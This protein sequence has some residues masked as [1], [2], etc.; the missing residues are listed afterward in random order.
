METDFQL[1][2]G[3]HLDFLAKL[4]QETI[5]ANCYHCFW[6]TSAQTFLQCRCYFWQN[7]VFVYKRDSSIWTHSFYLENDENSPSFG[8][9]WNFS[10]LEDEKLWLLNVMDFQLVI[11]WPFLTCLRWSFVQGGGSG[12]FVMPR[13]IFTKLRKIYFF[14]KNFY[15]LFVFLIKLQVILWVDC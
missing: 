7:P 6:K 9:W 14:N 13:A 8:K 10:L 11:L 15:E 1:I 4:I 3:A 2:R 5:S 12:Y